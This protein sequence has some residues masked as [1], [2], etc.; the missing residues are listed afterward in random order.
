MNSV[1]KDTVGG[2][3]LPQPYLLFLGDSTEPGF[4]KTASGLVDWAADR[5]VGEFGLAGCS[6]SVG[7]PQMSPAQAR[8]A[9]ARSLV[10]GVANQGGFI[11]D[12]WISALVEALD[13]GLDVVSGMHSR[14]EAIPALADAARRSGRQLINVRVPPAGIPIGTGRKRSGKRLLTVGTDCALGKK[15]TALALHRAFVSRGIDADFRATGQTG[16]MIAGRGIP[17]DAVVSDFEAGAAEMLSPDAAPDHWDLIEGQG[18]LFNPA[19]AAVSLGL[20]HG[21][22]PDVFVVC[23][24]PTRTM[25][26]GLD[27]YPMPT[28]DEVID[29]TIRLGSRTNPAIRCAG[30]SLN[31]SMLAA[32]DAEALMTSEAGRLGLPVADPI[33]GGPAFRALVDACLG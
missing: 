20:L 9:G 31:T 25:V 10:I 26:L 7:L 4:A 33:R 29:L 19:Y 8:A 22:Q 3:S 17:M 11:S 2:L 16:I 27:G 15:Y 13:A 28:I 24:D 1:L 12:A 14:L 6:V 5:C 30:V 21:S 32:A 18:S 23:H